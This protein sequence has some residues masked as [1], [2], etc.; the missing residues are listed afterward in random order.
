MDTV[1]PF[2]IP[3]VAGAFGPGSQP[4][5]EAPAVLPMPHDMSTYQGPS[6]PEREA[7]GAR[8]GVLAVLHAV[9]EALA[10]R[11]EGDT[12]AP[13]ELD[14][15]DDADRAL[16][17]Q[18]LGE[19]EVA[20]QVSLAQG[21]QA[22]ESV[23]AGV[24]RVLH[25]TDGRLSRDTLEVGP[26][27]AAV[28]EA[29]RQAALA[30]P[31]STAG[32]PEGTMNAPSVLAELRERQRRWQPGD[33]GHVINLSLLPLSPADSTCLDAEVGQGPVAIL[34]RG[35]GNCRIVSTRLPRTWRVTYFN[36]QDMVILDTLEVAAVPDVACAARQD[37]ED[38][39]ERLDEVL[40][41]VEAP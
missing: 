12:P 17:D 21:L 35:Y 10:R 14:G 11:L 5:G 27:P 3:L 36:S 30:R 20:V 13:I 24:W 19:G 26:I 1:K 31:A 34:S 15:L 22:Q 25:L 7:L 18:V 8:R 4:E 16:L 6:L 28:P 9:R 39:A 23:F 38:S 29:A 33:A 37:L 40:A 2:P 32:R 41:W